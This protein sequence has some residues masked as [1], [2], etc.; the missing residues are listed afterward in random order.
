M[1][2]YISLLPATL[3]FMNFQNLENRNKNKTIG[4]PIEDPE[5]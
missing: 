5:S 1:F 4:F 2:N 3:F